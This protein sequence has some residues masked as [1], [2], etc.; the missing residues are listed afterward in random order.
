MNYRCW[1]KCI[2]PE[3]GA[4]YPINTVIYRCAKCNNLLE[5]THDMKALAARS[6]DQ[7]RE[8]FDSRYKSS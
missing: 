1:F 7:W 6:G 4:E 2:D 8:T 3:C 5:V